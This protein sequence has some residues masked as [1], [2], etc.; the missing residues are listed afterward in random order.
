MLRFDHL[1]LRRGIKLLISDASFTLHAGWKVGVIGGNG[2]GKSSLF[3][4]IRRELQPDAG[5]LS[6]PPKLEIAH[7]AQETPALSR[8]AIDY[9]IDGDRELREIEGRLAQAEADQDGAAQAR[10]HEQLH[11]VDGYRARARAGQLL[12]GLGFSAAE[13]QQPVS[14]FSGGWRMRL[15]LAQALMC[16]S[17]LL[18]LDEPTNHL[19]LDAV[20]WLEAWLRDYE[21][22]L[23][24]IS[25]DREFLDRVV[26]HVVHLEQTR[27]Q[28]YTGNYS[29]FEQTRAARLANQQVEFE[30]QQREIAHIRRYVDRFR[31]KATKA[32]QAQSR[33]KALERMELIGPAHV[34]SQFRFRFLDPEKLP[35]PLLQVDDCAAGYAGTAILDSINLVLQPGDR[36]GLLGPNGAGKS[37]LVKLLAGALEPMRGRC[38]PAQDLHIGYFAQH[39]LEQLDSQASPLLHLQRLDPTAG[40]QQLRDFLG[41]FGFAGDQALAPVAPFSGGEKARLVLA[42]LV[43]QQPN[44]LLLDEPTNHLD[45][46]MRHA[47][48]QALQDFSGAMLIVSHDRHL[49]RIT[50]DQLWLVSNGSIEDFSGDLD[51]YPGWLMEHRRGLSE[52]AAAA[53]G[54]HTAAARKERKRLAAELR[55][56]FQPLREHLR[57]IERDLAQH[58]SHQ[59]RL[60]ARL[61]DTA[62]YQP[63][64]KDELK[65]CLAEKAAIDRLI[66]DVEENWLEISEKLEAAQTSESY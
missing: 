64:R 22:T 50:S 16:R 14:S 20:I 36:I 41:G 49:L 8:A 53:T 17:D 39:Q 35:H 2:S 5:D 25:H 13:E 51:D 47:L 19:D 59:Q 1:T 12:H 66:A 6:L 4:L 58:H 21:G 11:H 26:D 34:D 32:R 24:L 61:A 38:M 29:A 48:G 57:K 3:A 65:Q 46:E 63:E 55:R 9:V 37:T 27:A 45:L 42:L 43:Y 54:E 23:L 33:L 7:V 40:E 60:A 18:L 15:N 56:Q 30:K 44:L 28:L 52:Q 10:L 62:L 31:A